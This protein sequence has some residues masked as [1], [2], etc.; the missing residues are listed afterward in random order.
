MEINKNRETRE[1]G[2]SYSFDTNDRKPACNFYV[3]KTLGNMERIM[4]S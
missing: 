2:R 1:I 4:R 3:Y